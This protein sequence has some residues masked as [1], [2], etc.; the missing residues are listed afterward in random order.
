[1]T[2]RRSF[3]RSLAVAAPV[4]LDPAQAL[5]LLGFDSVTRVK[6]FHLKSL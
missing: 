1:M 6:S 4:L 5:S 2:D 3:V